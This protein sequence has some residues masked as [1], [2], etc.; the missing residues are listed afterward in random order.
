MIVPWQDEGMV[1]LSI[2]DLSPIIQG[3]TAAQALRNTLDLAQRAEAWGYRRFWLAEHHNMPGVAGADVAARIEPVQRAARRRIRAAVRLC[4]SL[5]TGSPDRCVDR[6]PHAIQA[7]GDAARTLCHG[8]RR[9]FRGRY[10]CRG[11]ALVHV[12]PAA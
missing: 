9:N 12:G 11:T 7:V 3:G 8:R 10:R 6:V 5:R 1:P 2:L 4:L